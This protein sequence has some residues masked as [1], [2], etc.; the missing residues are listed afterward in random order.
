MMH[1]FWVPL[2]A[3]GLC[4]VG[5]CVVMIAMGAVAMRRRGSGEFDERPARGT[6]GTPGR[7]RGVS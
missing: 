2:L 4:L 1:G 6:P 7:E 3:M 5:F